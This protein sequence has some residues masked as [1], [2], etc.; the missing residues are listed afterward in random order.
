MAKSKKTIRELVEEVNNSEELK[1]KIQE[2]KELYSQL[3]TKKGVFD[4]PDFEDYTE[5]RATE[6][7]EEGLSAED[8]MDVNE[9]LW[10]NQN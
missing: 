1:N 4:H 10:F 8:V 5:E 7:E 3:L 6:L 2:L 9:A